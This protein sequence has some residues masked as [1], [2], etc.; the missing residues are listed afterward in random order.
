M[1]S[2]GGG[3]RGYWT[4]LVL[5]HL[6]GQIARI[7]QKLDENAPV[8]ESA[9]HSF[10]P[11][12]YPK[13][14]SR[15]ISVTERQRLS[16]A[17]AQDADEAQALH[18]SR[19][20]L[21]CHYFDYVC[22]SS[23]GALIAIMLGRFRMPVQDCL[24]EYANLVSQ[25]FGKPRFITKMNF[26]VGRDKYSTE[27]LENVFKA[28]TKRRC[29]HAEGGNTYNSSFPSRRKVCKTFVTTLKSKCNN[30]QE[31]R[32]EQYLIRSY[33]HHEQMA[34][35]LWSSSRVNSGLSRATEGSRHLPR[36]I[37]L[38]PAEP[39]EVW[40]VARAATAAP[41]YFK[42]FEGPI[43]HANDS[44][45]R[46][47]DGGLHAPNNP[48]MEGIREIED[49]NGRGSLHL[50]VSIGTARTNKPPGKSLPRTIENLIELGNDPQ[51][52]HRSVQR[53]SRSETSGFKYFRFNDEEGTEA[54]M[55]E[56]E[57]RRGASAGSRTFERLRNRFYGWANQ[58][59]VHDELWKCA[60]FLVKQRRKRIIDRRAWETYATG[61]KYRCPVRRC[62]DIFLNRYEVKEH[63]EQKH[64]ESINDETINRLRDYFRYQRESL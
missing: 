60:V 1:L 40:Q 52:I 15:N 4:L 45:S 32:R 51:T 5:N 30:G 28:V 43:D 37:N 31:E 11:E 21:V 27:N 34:Y 41:L 46:F 23:T 25:V 2:D 9:S 62:E 49:L 57:P 54:G 59:E 3:V 10:H 63:V 18:P 20:Y 42:P 14:V 64:D 16:E 33:D 22:G 47:V 50:V 29:E 39:M 56:C 12:K 8:D 26:I 7:E 61:S 13:S 55:D 48:T 58:Q 36:T 44:F 24:D 17:E 19:R 35:S 53:D 38:G 6:I